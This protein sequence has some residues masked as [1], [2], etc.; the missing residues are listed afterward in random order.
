MNTAG[1]NLKTPRRKRGDP[2]YLHPVPV[3]IW[4]WLNAL[5][6]LILIL[7]GLQVRYIDL[8][9][10][11]TFESAVQWHNWV[12]FV[13]I[14]NWF[15]W[16]FY[17]LTSPRITNYQPD[18]DPAKFFRRYIR[19]VEYYSYGIFVGEKRPHDVRPH[20]KF[21]PMQKLTYQFVM[22]ITAPI[23][24]LTGLMMWDVE[25]F[26]GLI[27]LF[28]GLRIVNTVHMVMCILFVFFITVHAY[29]GFLGAKPITHYREMFTGWEEPH[30]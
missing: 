22:F 2:A 26:Q 13:V 20:D 27:D 3:R 18:L 30:D 23:T 16:F 12:G 25:R 17:Y 19:Q 24:F 28:G 7:T 5:G 15:L 1:S 6:F 8:F 21:N 4:H 14:V 29:M 10:L 11:M 9:S